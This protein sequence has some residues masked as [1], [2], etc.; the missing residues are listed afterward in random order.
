MTYNPDQ[1]FGQKKKLP[2]VT[3]DISQTSRNISRTITPQK[4]T[5]TP[6]ANERVE[7]QKDILNRINNF[8]ANNG[9]SPN[10]KIGN[11]S[12][13]SEDF[14]SVNLDLDGIPK[15]SKKKIVKVSK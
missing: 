8:L 12:Q 10:Q 4:S 13:K 2:Q 14:N 3:S 11:Q 15:V 5:P 1:L 6:K 7:A 9:N